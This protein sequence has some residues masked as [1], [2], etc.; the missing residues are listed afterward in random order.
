MA[1][2]AGVVDAGVVLAVWL[3]HVY[4]ALLVLTALRTCDT[5]AARP[6]LS[7]AFGIK[8]HLVTSI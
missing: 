8:H 5:P 6:I 2:H 1:E 7:V 3:Q 4:A